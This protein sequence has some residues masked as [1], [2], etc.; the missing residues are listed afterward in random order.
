[1]KTIRTTS[2]SYA[3]ETVSLSKTTLFFS[4]NGVQLKS[5]KSPRY[6]AKLDR[7][8]CY[9]TFCV[10]W[11]GYQSWWST[12]N[13]SF[14]C[15]DS[16]IFIWNK[17]SIRDQLVWI[18]LKWLATFFSMIFLYMLYLWLYEAYLKLC[19]SRTLFVTAWSSMVR[20]FPHMHAWCRLQRAVG[21]THTAE[22]Q[23][24]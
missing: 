3:L 14:S 19:W 7:M 22:F 24:C 20:L 5:K 16:M 21:T 18:A 4:T 10:C 23:T 6:H 11:I 17:K 2:Q 12:Q 9:A 15:S 1:M 8:A 13:W